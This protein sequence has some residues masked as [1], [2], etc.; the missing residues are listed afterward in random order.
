LKVTESCT[1]VCMKYLQVSE[2]YSWHLGKGK[3]KSKGEVH[4]RTD[5]EGP[6]S[7]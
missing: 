2:F 3:G 5:H 1:Y 6:E 7:E 4:P